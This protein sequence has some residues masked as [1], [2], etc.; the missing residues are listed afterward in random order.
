MTE[1]RGG[2]T[3]L[4]RPVTGQGGGGGI[5]EQMRVDR[6]AEGGPGMG[7]DLAVGLV[8]AEP[9]APVAE[10]QEGVALVVR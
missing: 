2:E 4:R 3:D 6:S 10:P 7:G 1:Q 9:P 5:A 8:V